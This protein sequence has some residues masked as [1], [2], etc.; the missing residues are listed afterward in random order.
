[1]KHLITTAAMLLLAACAGVP[2]QAGI[3]I[4]YSA[5]DYQAMQLANDGYPSNNDILSLTGQDGTLNLTPGS[6]ITAPLAVF[7]FTSGYS[8]YGV[9]TQ[10]FDTGTAHPW[11]LTVGEFTQTVSIPFSVTSDY[12]TDTLR[13]Q[14]APILSF[15]VH[16]GSDTVI[17]EALGLT[18]HAFLSTT[19]GVLYGRFTLEPTACSAISQPTPEPSTFVVGGTLA[20]LGVVTTSLR[21]RRS[22]N[23]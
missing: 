10:F 2:A 22:A 11:Q 17:V 13:M 1:M 12:S 15:P 6:S 23:R 19:E 5:G 7:D 14:N 16:G 21:R 4:D 9:I 20:F 8:S 3:S 18:S